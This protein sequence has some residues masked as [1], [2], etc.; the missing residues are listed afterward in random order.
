MELKQ[1]EDLTD[2]M[3]NVVDTYWRLYDE[4][5]DIPS[6]YA[7]AKEAYDKCTNTM[8]RYTKKQ[9]P[10][11][12]EHGT[13]GEELSV[14]ILKLTRGDKLKEGNYTLT[15]NDDSEGYWWLT[16]QDGDTSHIFSFD[17]IVIMSDGTYGLIRDGN[18]SNTLE[19]LRHSAAT[20]AR[21]LDLLAKAD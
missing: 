6:N 19:N 14:W 5:G 11:L 4:S 1:K 2:K 8:V 13:R 12:F 15:Y 3:R 7:V 17:S 16:Y 9:Y 20:I 21:V 10:N 18:Y